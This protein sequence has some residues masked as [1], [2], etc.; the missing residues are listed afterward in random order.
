MTISAII[1]QPSYP[2]SPDITTYASE[3]I[4]T[5]SD[6]ELSS[7]L[8]SSSLELSPKID[9]V[10]SRFITKAE[11]KR[12]KALLTTEVI[13][14]DKKYRIEINLI[15]FF[16]KLRE[17]LN[18]S[19]SLCGSSV[20]YV[21]NFNESYN[22]KDFIFP[23]NIPLK[24]SLASKGG[25]NVIASSLI[26]AEASRVRNI[27]EDLL[28]EQF[29]ITYS[30]SEPLT[31]LDIF[32][33]FFSSQFLKIDPIDLEK[34]K[35]GNRFS[36]LKF[37]EIEIK[38]AY[39]LIV[40]WADSPN[41]IFI[42]G[43]E[44]P[45][46]FDKDS[47]HIPLKPILD[48]G[49][50]D[51]LQTEIVSIIGSIDEALFCLKIGELKTNC[52]DGSKFIKFL[53]Y[54]TFRNS[55]CDLD[56]AKELFSN[57]VEKFSL[58]EIEHR[59][60][61]Y[62]LGHLEKNKL[63]V[64]TA[65]LNM[66][67]LCKELPYPQVEE[68]IKE[69]I[70]SL[71]PP[72]SQNFLLSH[73]DYCP[74]VIDWML[75]FINL[76]SNKLIMSE[77]KDKIFI[78]FSQEAST[79]SLFRTPITL[80][81]KHLLE[82]PCQLL[83]LYKNFL[84]QIRSD[85][86]LI[87]EQELAQ[88]L[89]EKSEPLIVE[90][91]DLLIFYQFL[92]S[93]N[94]YPFQVS[95]TA[96]FNLLSPQNSINEALLY[97]PRALIELN[98]VSEKLTLLKQFAHYSLDITRLI[99]TN[100]KDEITISIIKSLLHTPHNHNEM[101]LLFYDL[102]DRSQ[103]LYFN[104]LV[105]AL[106]PSILKL[107]FL[108][109]LKKNL[110]DGLE[111]LL[112]AA[113]KSIIP[114]TN[115]ENFIEDTSLVIDALIKCGSDAEKLFDSYPD[116]FIVLIHKYLQEDLIPKSFYFF[117]IESKII[118][119]KYFLAKL[120]DHFDRISEQISNEKLLL[121]EILQRIK[122]RYCSIHLRENHPIFIQ[123]LQKWVLKL[124]DLEEKSAFKAHIFMEYSSWI[125]FPS[126]YFEALSVATKYLLNTK[127]KEFILKI[128]SLFQDELKIA[129]LNSIHSQSFLDL[130][131]E[132]I[133][134]L[135]ENNKTL[136]S[137]YFEGGRNEVR[138]DIKSVFRAFNTLHF[139]MNN[140]SEINEETILIIY[141]LFEESLKQLSNVP[142]GYL[143]SKEMCEVADIL[144][145][146]ISK[147]INCS[148]AMQFFAKSFS[149][150]SRSDLIHIL[151]PLLLFY[152][153]TFTHDEET[154]CKIYAAIC[155]VEPS[156]NWN[157]FKLDEMLDNLITHCTSF[158]VAKNDIIPPILHVIEHL[159]KVAI[160]NR[161]AKVK[162]CNKLTTIFNHSY[163]RSLI[164]E[165]SKFKTI[166]DFYDKEVLSKERPFFRFTISI[167]IMDTL[168]NNMT[169]K[170]LKYP[171]ID[172]SK[173]LEICT[174]HIIL[175][176]EISVSFE[177]HCMLAEAIFTL[178]PSLKDSHY[179]IKKIGSLL[180]KKYLK[181]SII[182]QALWALK[183]SIEPLIERHLFLLKEINNK[184][185]EIWGKDKEQQDLFCHLIQQNTLALFID[186]TAEPYL[187]SILESINSNKLTLLTI[188]DF[189]FVFNQSLEQII[190]NL[191]PRGIS[192]NTSLIAPT[193]QR[194]EPLLLN[195]HYN[196][197]II[198]ITCSL[199]NI[200][201]QQNDF[202]I[203]T[204]LTT[205]SEKCL[206][207]SNKEKLYFFITALHYLTTSYTHWKIGL[208]LLKDS[209]IVDFL[210]P[211]DIE[212]LK[213]NAKESLK[214]A[215]DKKKTLSIDDI[216]YLKSNFE[217][218]L[219]H[220]NDITSWSVDENNILIEKAFLP[221]DEII[222]TSKNILQRSGEIFNKLFENA[223]KNYTNVFI[224]L[225]RVVDC[226]DP[227]IALVNEKCC[228]NIAQSIIETKN[229]LIDALLQL[230]KEQPLNSANLDKIEH[231]KNQFE[232]IKNALTDRLKIYDPEIE[233]IKLPR[234]Y[235]NPLIPS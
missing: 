211:H 147:K 112:I 170:E 210:D 234:L 123:F 193:I 121:K 111:T 208:N 233:P 177:N 174:G 215:L 214:C 159:Q 148:M 28:I 224:G 4:S 143:T 49:S 62:F 128:N 232:L 199:I 168:F 149:K 157:I 74:L 181:I 92:H 25:L 56:L 102:S 78:T 186:N 190:E 12:L 118:G 172:L 219:K 129:L 81:I 165:S 1:N 2:S 51:P 137:D 38:V 201:E 139:L 183:I 9:E 184:A 140:S 53:D 96:L 229:C 166:F 15:F 161:D 209:R 44:N 52:P 119:H 75:L 34:E 84:L 136:S 100:E 180:V 14:L 97:L 206:T 226:K 142:G 89:I 213:S 227:I 30:E 212:K 39:N 70:H 158:K 153:T 93:Y 164:L 124:V 19:P 141:P 220:L 65:L 231:F 160:H 150:D 7:S 35:R 11:A 17:L 222:E 196:K 191:L 54:I 95:R 223:L 198:D 99:D 117:I 61:T 90:Q 130:T 134:S 195:T 192:L 179:T 91:E 127:N 58:K 188:K 167:L 145:I 55:F 59:I 31:R 203:Q 138:Q 216:F 42:G 98:S 68:K 230:S 115:A 228:L 163:F 26:H 72:K 10:S 152:S 225:K 20:S 69:I 176:E 67:I 194:L 187:F 73:P 18:T 189:L 113:F 151:E 146:F 94:R 6:Y 13:S 29:K 63:G 218:L 205:F 185:I 77:K 8:S 132:V 88:L 204:W 60:N 162:L 41:T 23:I 156:K 173:V 126:N 131:I 46:A 125:P 86:I 108:D 101:V 104:F 21:V 154:N 48:T 122:E 171:I 36:L 83:P 221:I 175:Q 85:Q 116:F 169:K 200:A 37:G 47:L 217:Q 135:L 33:L 64:I 40:E 76:F 202:S 107:L 109:L 16:Q 120:E 57:F 80:R 5:E 82:H 22:D 71:L 105:D 87:E 197:I 43:L 155:L 79:Y 103:V 182:H 207:L 50:V 3:E 24:I 133:T 27:V 235:E 66:Y 110:F 32:R 114:H 45:C 106:K 144:T 178:L